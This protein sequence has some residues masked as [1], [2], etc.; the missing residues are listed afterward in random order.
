MDKTNNTENHWL[1]NH[2]SNVVSQHGEDGILNKIFE[3]IPDLNKWCVEFGAWDGK[4]LSNTW[5]LITNK[6]WSAVMIEANPKRYK[7]LLQTYKGNYNVLPIKRWVE[8]EG[9]NTLDNIFSETKLPLDFDLISID[10]DGNDYHIWD[11][12]KQFKPKVVVIEYNLTIPN[13]IEFIQARD[14]SVNQSSSLLAITNLG[15]Q[16]GYELVA[17][18]KSNA[19]FVKKQYFPLFNISDNSLDAINP[20]TNIPRVY[21]LY[22]G[23]IVLTDEF[24]LLWHSRIPVKTRTMQVLP[25]FFRFYNDTSV[26]KIKRIIKK[27]Y[28]RLKYKIS[29]Y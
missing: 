9:K 13:D 27:I 16:K 5:N 1:L 19:I 23:T 7:E 3:I 28:I 8:F 4:F 22:D 20:Q 26:S 14:M 6:E 15:K 12:L 10:I 25:R 2:S 18:T 29:F 24:H 21:Q 17:V 11:S